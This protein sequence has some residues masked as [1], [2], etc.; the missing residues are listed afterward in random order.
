MFTFLLH[1]WWLIVIALIV[2][3]VLYKAARK[4]IGALVVVVIVLMVLFEVFAASAFDAANACLSSS[5]ERIVAFTEEGMALPAGSARNDHL[6]SAA[7]EDYERLEQCLADVGTE[8]SFGFFLY[9]RV[10]GFRKMLTEP[11]QGQ[12]RVCPDHPL[13]EPDFLP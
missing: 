12:N 11:V 9:M 4:I 6:C 5:T 3:A 2:L 7:Q 8:N 1:F 10:P 13:S